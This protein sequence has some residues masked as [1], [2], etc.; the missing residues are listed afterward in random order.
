MQTRVGGT[1]KKKELIQSTEKE[2]THLKKGTKASKGEK[3]EEDW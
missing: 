3:T 1:K 2:E